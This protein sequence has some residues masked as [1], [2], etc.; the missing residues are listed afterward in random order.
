MTRRNGA[1]GDPGKKGWAVQALHIFCAQIQSILQGQMGL[2]CFMLLP[3]T[4]GS[5]S[6]VMSTTEMRWSHLRARLGNTCS[7]PKMHDHKAA[8]LLAPL[9]PSSPCRPQRS[10]SRA[11]ILP[12]EADCCSWDCQ[13]H[14]PGLL[15]STGTTNS[16]NRARPREKGITRKY[17][18]RSST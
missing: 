9:P 16:P 8:F 5:L 12:E 6:L 17:K 10:R 2:V 3:C 11:L 4:D 15:Q 7:F 13:G 18:T 1:W 14:L